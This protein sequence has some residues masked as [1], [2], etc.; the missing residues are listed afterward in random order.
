[1]DIEAFLIERKK[2]CKKQG[3][4]PWKQPGRGWEL[5]DQ[6]GGQVGTGRLRSREKRS[7]ACPPATRTHARSVDG[8]GCSHG[9]AILPQHGHM[10]CA[11][12][13]APG[14]GQAI[15]AELVVTPG[16]DLLADVLGQSLPQQVLGDVLE[17]A[18]RRQGQ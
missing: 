8:A 9:T 5:G 2:K 11:H 3:A 15:V 7:E 12:A 16:I 13:V 4:A 10:G 6:A 18:V 1:M 17:W 14:P